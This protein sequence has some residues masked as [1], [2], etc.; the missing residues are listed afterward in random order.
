MV[1]RVTR[2]GIFLPIRRS[3]SGLLEKFTRARSLG[4]DMLE[5]Y[6]TLSLR[7]SHTSKR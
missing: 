6:N 4:R 1:D 3:G 5:V 7:L 2:H